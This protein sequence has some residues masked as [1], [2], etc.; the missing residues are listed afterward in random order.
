MIEVRRRVGGGGFS[1]HLTKHNLTTALFGCRMWPGGHVTA[2][3][4][5]WVFVTPK[6]TFFN[7]PEDKRTLICHV[8]IMALVRRIAPSR[9]N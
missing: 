7:L 8:A 2:R 6:D 3:S 4:F 5:L 1:S 9:Q